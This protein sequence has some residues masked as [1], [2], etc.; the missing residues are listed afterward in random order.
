MVSAVGTGRVSGIRFE[1][2]FFVSKARRTCNEFR[3][4]L[5]LFPA[6]SFRLSFAVYF[7]G[8]CRC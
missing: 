4:E 6:L 5:N 7:L 1:S 3:I 2:A 8:D